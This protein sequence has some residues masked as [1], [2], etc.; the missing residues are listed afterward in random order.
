MTTTK[1]PTTEQEEEVL[2]YLNDLRESGITNMF[3]A[4]PYII[5]NFIV[6]EEEA[7]RLLMLWMK[8]YNSDSNYKEVTA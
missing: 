1:R 2:N 4:R 7:K 6:D 8:N 3:D 5:E